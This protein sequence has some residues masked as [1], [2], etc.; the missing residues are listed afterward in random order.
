LVIDYWEE[1]QKN[2]QLT[3]GSNE[4]FSENRSDL[5][6]CQLSSASPAGYDSADSGCC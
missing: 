6:K 4:F 5:A 2:C 3:K 1:Y